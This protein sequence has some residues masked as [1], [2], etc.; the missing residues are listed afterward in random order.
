MQTALSKQDGTARSQQ[1]E[2]SQCALKHVEMEF[3][4]DL[5]L[6]MTLMYFQ[7]MGAPPFVLSSLDGHAT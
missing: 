3:E 1:M 5:K 4:R 6:V 2:V 7:M